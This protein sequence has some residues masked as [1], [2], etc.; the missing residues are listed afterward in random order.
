VSGVER[1]RLWPC[2]DA[3]KTLGDSDLLGLLSRAK[4]IS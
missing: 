4:S 2:P 1:R 3:W